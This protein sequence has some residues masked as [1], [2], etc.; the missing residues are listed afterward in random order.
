MGN[1]V[2]PHGQNSRRM[3]RPLLRNCR[4]CILPSLAYSYSEATAMDSRHHR[5]LSVCQCIGC[6]PKNPATFETRSSTNQE[7]L[8]GTTKK[9]KPLEKHLPKLAS[10]GN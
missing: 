2:C 7:N 9:N 8:T 5:E 10:S 4:C 3:R 1:N 6:D